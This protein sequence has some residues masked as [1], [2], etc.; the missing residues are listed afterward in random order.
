MRAFGNPLQ[1]LIG[2]VRSPRETLT[3]AVLAPR[4]IDL[5]IVIVVVAAACSAGFLMTRVGQLAAL[6]QQVRLLESFGFAVNDE[7]YAELPALGCPY[8][9]AIS[10][11]II[12][13]GWPLIWVALAAIVKGA[14][15]GTHQDSRRFAQVLTVV[16][17]ASVIFALRE[18]V[19]APVNYARE[20][21]GGATSL[22]M[23][24]PAFGEST[25]TARLLGAVDH[26]RRV[27]GGARRDGTWHSV[28]NARCTGRAL[29]ALRV[30][31]RRRR[32]CDHASFARRRLGVAKQ[33]NHRR[34]AGPRRRWR[35]P[36]VMPG[37]PGARR[38]RS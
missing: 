13:I 21:I 14:G 12:L 23:L 38:R 1:R 17:H 3:I 16:V 27:V 36:A 4:S 18:A 15:D 5:A 19:A 33:E 9:P 28:R 2:M 34:R 6:D 35:P 31:G 30:H 10:A 37:G 24:M 8:R 32:A 25:F 29:A 7:T 11:G 26:F 20:S 22:S